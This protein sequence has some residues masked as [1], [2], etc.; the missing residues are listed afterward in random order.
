VTGGISIA[1]WVGWLA[2]AAPFAALLAS[3]YVKV[4]VVLSTLRAALGRAVPPR[5]VTAIVAL[6]LACFAAAPVAAPMWRAARPAVE[7]GDAAALAQGGADAQAPLAAFLAKHTP[8]R[9]RRSFLELARSLRAPEDRAAVDEND[10]L[11]GVTAFVA[12]ELKAAF[13][14]GFLL[15]LPFLVLEL[16][17]AAVLGTLG[18]HALDPR[19]VALPFKL[20]LFVLADGWHLLAR[21]LLLG[22]T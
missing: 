21:G 8:E 3:A 6:L 20:L 15:F 13:Q 9:E 1:G 11:V 19:A 5:S 4:A 12:A 14:V 22:Y 18:A 7:K 17:V 10:L 2:V 16:V